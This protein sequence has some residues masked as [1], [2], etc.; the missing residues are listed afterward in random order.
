MT[1][2]TFAMQLEM[3]VP[4]LLPLRFVTVIEYPGCSDDFPQCSA[5]RHRRRALLTVLGL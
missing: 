3:H 5:T 2:C 1:G 4:V